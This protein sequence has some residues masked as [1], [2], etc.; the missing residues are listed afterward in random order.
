VMLKNGT[1]KGII[2]HCLQRCR[3]TVEDM[4]A[5]LAV[6]QQRVARLEQAYRD[7]LAKGDD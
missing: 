7:E 4:E 6:Q 1:R 2:L 3:S 5:G